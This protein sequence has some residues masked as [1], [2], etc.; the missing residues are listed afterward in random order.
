[1]S[2]TPA[3][4]ATSCLDDEPA[5]LAASEV[6]SVADGVWQR[7][8]KADDFATPAC[9]VPPIVTETAMSDAV[10]SGI[11]AAAALNVA[12]ELGHEYRHKLTSVSGQ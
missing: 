5:G 6:E 7:V 8:A 11:L 1:M 10:L 2:N 4:P 9:D 3:L 12:G